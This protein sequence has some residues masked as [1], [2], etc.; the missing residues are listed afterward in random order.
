MH[1]TDPPYR[2]TH[3]Q[4]N[5]A[6]RATTSSSARAPTPHTAPPLRSTPPSAARPDRC[7][8]CLSSIAFTDCAES[9]DRLTASPAPTYK[10]NRVVLRM[11]RRARRSSSARLSSTSRASGRHS[12]S[13]NTTGCRVRSTY[14]DAA[15]AP[16][17]AAWRAILMAITPHSDT[18]THTHSR[19]PGHHREPLHRDRRHRVLPG[20][21]HF[22]RSTPIHA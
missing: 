5:R 18:T 21:A 6:S 17:L 15:A 13:G 20:T 9:T 8:I 2:S 3:T 4:H 7:V 11:W 1:L 22:I 16:C 12:P 14:T 19:L 10:T